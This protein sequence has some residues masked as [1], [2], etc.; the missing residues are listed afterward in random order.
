MLAL[1]TSAQF[2]SVI[3]T[4]AKRKPGNQKGEATKTFENQNGRKTVLRLPVYAFFTASPQSLRQQNTWK[5][6]QN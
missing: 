6:Q 5:I 4:E 2:T 1:N 3:E